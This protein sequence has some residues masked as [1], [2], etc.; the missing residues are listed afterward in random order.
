LLLAMCTLTA[1]LTISAMDTP[2]ESE[3]TFHDSCSSCV[4]RMRNCLDAGLPG[5]LLV[6]VLRVIGEF[7]MAASIAA[8]MLSWYSFCSGSPFTILTNSPEKASCGEPSM[9]LCTMSEMKL[10]ILR[11]PTPSTSLSLLLLLGPISNGNGLLPM[12]R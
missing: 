7:V 12:F 2:R 8:F 4:M 3:K 1:S 5:S 10:D 11:N 9:G 6:F